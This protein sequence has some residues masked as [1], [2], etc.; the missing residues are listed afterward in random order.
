MF[1]HI[2]FLQ[3][4][5]VS[6]VILHVFKLRFGR[7][8][9]SPVQG[10][11]F[12]FRKSLLSNIDISRMST[13][14]TDH[15]EDEV[16]QPSTSHHINKTHTPLASGSKAAKKRKHAAIAPA[17]TRKYSKYELFGT[18]SE[19]ESDEDKS[20]YEDTVPAL[21]KLRPTSSNKGEMKKMK[22]EKR[23][24]S[25]SSSKRTSRVAQEPIVKASA[26]DV[27]GSDSD[28]EQFEQTVRKTG[29]MPAKITSYFTKRIPQGVSRQSDPNKDGSH[30]IEL[31]VY[32]CD[33]IRNVQPMNRWRHAIISIKNQSDS[34]T[35][36]WT[37]LT[38]FIKATRHE[39][40]NCRPDIISGYSTY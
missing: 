32:R 18:D 8:C 37:H 39:F 3:I 4:W 27:F 10:V 19:D 40:K 5:K 9:H 33:E 13:H 22:A 23:E 15:S 6:H 20:T 17:P 21:K 34:D 11:Q 25:K 26:K 30:F 24:K 2:V 29:K 28:D 16:A 12:I 31:K 35:E 38:Q 1:S 14:G 7:K 36:A